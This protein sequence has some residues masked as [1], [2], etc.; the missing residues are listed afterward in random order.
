MRTACLAFF[1]FAIT[2]SSV[3]VSAQAPPQPRTLLAFSNHATSVPGFGFYGF[4]KS[5]NAGNMYV[6]PT[7]GFT[8]AAVLRIS[9]SKYEPTTY[10]LPREMRDKY[11]ILDFAVSPG[12]SVWALADSSDH[13]AVVVFAFDSKGETKGRIGFGLPRGVNIYTFLASDG[14]VFLLSGNYGDMAAKELQGQPYIGLFDQSGNLLRLLRGVSD[15]VDLKEM[16]SFPLE[17]GSAVGEDGS[18]YLLDAKQITVLNPAGEVASRI[19][20][21]KPAS[22]LRMAGMYVSGGLATIRLARLNKDHSVHFS[23]L[24]MDLFS[25]QTIGWY[26]AD[27]SIGYL[28][29]F[30]RTEGFTFEHLEQGTIHLIQAQLK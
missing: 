6:H 28:V 17:S 11:N 10:T 29:G 20:V 16:G 27:S 25:K 7:E 15:T 12:G 18:F 1:A 13:T 21:S 24:V 14:E 9:S 30:S 19:P 2:I 26:V 5:D 23:Y 4:A 8:Q 3:C 22:D